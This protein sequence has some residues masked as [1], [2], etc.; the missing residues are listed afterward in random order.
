MRRMGESILLTAK[1]RAEAHGVM[2]QTVVRHGEV[3]T[4]TSEL[5]HELNSDYLALGEPGAKGEE[6]C[7]PRL[8]KLSLGSKSKA[9]PAHV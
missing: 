1:P 6:M 2:A 8:S 9:R 5:C 3:M 7:L 4:E